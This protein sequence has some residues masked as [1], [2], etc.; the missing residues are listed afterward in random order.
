MED[1]QLLLDDIKR[2]KESIAFY[3]DCV[4][5][6]KETVNVLLSQIKERDNF[7]KELAQERNEWAERCSV[8]SDDLIKA[9]QELNA[10][11]IPIMN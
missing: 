8:K 4:N 6:Y 10:Y 5:Q 7:I 2:L 3:Q 11:R 9:L 1:N